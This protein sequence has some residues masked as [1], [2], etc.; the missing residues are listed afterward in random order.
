MAA[1]LMKTGQS[2]LWI[3]PEELEKVESAITKEEV[4]KLIHEGVIATKPKRG[5]SRGRYRTK[6]RKKKGRGQGSIEGSNHN[7]KRIWVGK[8]RNLRF[9]LRAL[10]TKRII[11]KQIYRKLLPMAKGGAFRSVSHLDEYLEAHDLV[12]RR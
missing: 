11:T 6:A 7:R 5:V 12:R 2:R 1:S 4:R 8:I 9:R 10:R 3:N